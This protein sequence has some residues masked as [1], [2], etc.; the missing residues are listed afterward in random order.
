MKSTLQNTDTQNRAS[1]SS[2]WHGWAS[3]SVLGTSD[4]DGVMGEVLYFFPVTCSVSRG[5]GQAHR[6]LQL[7]IIYPK[8]GR[9]SRY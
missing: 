2:Q 1:R 5:E 7:N 3:V 4:G 8:E 6:Q 9:D